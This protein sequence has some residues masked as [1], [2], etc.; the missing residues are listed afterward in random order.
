M[1]ETHVQTVSLVGHVIEDLTY[2]PVRPSQF[3]AEILGTGHIPQYKSGG[4]FVFSNVAP[5]TYTLRVGGQRFQPLEQ[6][7][8]VPAA[9]HVINREGDNAVLVIA[10]GV[11]SVPGNNGGTRLSF[12]TVLLEQPVRAGAAIL[13]PGFSATLAVE[14]DRGLAMEARIENVTGTLIPNAIVRI[15]RDQSLRLKVNP[16]SALPLTRTRLVGTVV[17]QNAPEVHLAGA[18]VRLTQVNGVTVES[19]DIAG[20]EVTSV[21]LNASTIILGTERDVTTLTNANGDYNLYFDIGEVLENLTVEVA[22]AGYQAAMA[23]VEIRTGQRQRLE[24]LLIE[25]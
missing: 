20:L 13:T 4:F 1:S 12:N 2:E 24:V 17:R 18:Q 8:E 5:G 23:T 6:T 16:Y 25:A 14:L 15:V 9:D 21:G 22:L 7:V 3:Q 10:R 11:T 19:H